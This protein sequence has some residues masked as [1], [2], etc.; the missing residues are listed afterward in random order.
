MLM[1]HWTCFAALGALAACAGAGAGAGG[2]MAEGTAA[3]SAAIRGLAEHY[4]AAMNSGDAS[5][6][7][8][9]IAS[10]YV[11]VDPTGK[12]TRGHDAVMA[13][14]DSAMKAMPM[15]QGMTMS[16]TTEYIRFMSPTSAVAGGTW[17]VS[18]STQPGMPTRGAWM[19]AAVKND[20]TWLL[21]ASLGA[22]DDSPMMAA[23]DS[24]S[25]AK[26]KGH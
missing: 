12:V 16:A 9:I 3:D 8:S 7:S 1:K 2:G 23:L 17:T 15:P 13:S 25:K 24:M 4:A 22:A 19:G 11:D 14:M 18:G 26:G 10:D 6:M 5:G 20:T 21:V